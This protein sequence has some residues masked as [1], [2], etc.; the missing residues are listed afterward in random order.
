M[1]P[2]LGEVL[3]TA[4][5][6]ILGGGVCAGVS[7]KKSFAANSGWIVITW[8][9]GLA[10]AIAVYAV[11]QFSGA[12]LNPAVT[13]ALAF[14]GDFPWND[15]PPYILAQFIGAIIGAVIVYLHYLPHWKET[16]DPGAKLGVFS[17]GP[18]ISHVFSNL[19]SEIIGTFI[20]VVG[21]LSIGANK[22]TDGLNPLIVGFLIL[23]LGLSLGGTTGYALNPARDLG[24]R[25]A[26]F[27]LPI[28]GKGGSN[29]GYAWIPVLGPILGGSFGG[30]FY[31][32]V[33]L[34]QM[35]P[36]FWFVSGVMAIILLVLYFISKK[37]TANSPNK[38]L[39]A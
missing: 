35:T 23:S 28:P 34:G 16:E 13:L 15:V 30:V 12:H 38:T 18:A 27:F 2:F 37:S 3:G 31:K 4:I 29:W 21:I 33:F 19:L 11:G 25:I 20:L 22:F 14:K 39:A 26:H 24:P 32:A 8:G 9:W 1:T 5:L 7:L 17:T 6:I 10:V 36:A